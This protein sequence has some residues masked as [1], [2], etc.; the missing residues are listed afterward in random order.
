VV[1]FGGVKLVPNTT[2]T[3]CETGIPAGWTLEWKVDT[4]GDGVPDSTIPFFAGGNSPPTPWT[5]YSNVYDPNY[6]APPG[7]YT[8]DTRCVQFTVQPDQTLAFE[9]NNAFPGGDPRT[10]GFWKNWNTCTG[11]NQVT[12]ATNN[13]GPLAGWF[14]LDDL[15]NSPGYLVGDLLLDG[16]DCVQATR[17][18]DKS[19]VVSG[20]KVA[21]D[22]AYNLA[23]QFLAAM[24]NLSAGAETCNQVTSA[25][26]AAQTL[27]DRIN[28]TGTGTYLKKGADYN[29][30]NSLASTLD[31][32][33]NGLLCTP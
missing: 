12:T 32:Y 17:I 31:K 15:L 19:D 33:N 2:Y 3:V 9:L 27:L 28:F 5:G 22:G 26:N 20:K 4:D 13:G 18:L 8:N 14:I 16:A 6:V 1:D 23:S 25:V 10:I 29:L 30:A 7:T 21:S 24:V 11:G